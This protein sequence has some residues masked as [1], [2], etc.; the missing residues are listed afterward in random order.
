MKNSQRNKIIIWGVVL[1]IVVVFLSLPIEIPYS[2]NTSGKI[3]PAKEML[4]I[5]SA[6]G[7][8]VTEM[9]DNIRGISTNYSAFQFIRGDAIQF[10]FNKNISNGSAVS[11]NDTIAFLYS[12][13]LE[14][15]LIDLRGE[16]KVAK[17]N[18][19]V[20]ETGEK[21]SIVDQSAK[22]LEYNKRQSAEQKRIL[23]NLEELYKKNLASKD[24][25]E[26]AKSLNDLYEINIGIAEAQLQSVQTGV[27]K[28]EIGYLKS[29]ITALQ[30]EADALTKR[31]NDYTIVSQINGIVNKPYKLDTLLV[32]SDTTEFVVLIPVLWEERE[33]LSINQAIQIDVPMLGKIENV[34]I[35]EIDNTVHLINH[36]QVF[37]VT[38]K[39][40]NGQA[41]LLPG[42]IV[43]SNIKCKPLRP[44]DYLKRIL[45]SF[46]N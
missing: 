25:Y 42:L 35:A 36:G 9:K 27:K 2:I 6:D 13:E 29:Q 20:L 22:Q 32:V 1:L 38:G 15:E 39:I 30:D 5:K 8:L 12:N 45:K 18:L 28:E 10:S 7:T 17:A 3:L 11:I 34:T 40:P 37:I 33:N 31:F 23:K 19:A 43:E 44:L 21:K 16:I 4:F 41:G 46:F 24:E 26:I 14:R